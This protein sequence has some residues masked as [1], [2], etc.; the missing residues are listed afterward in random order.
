MLE[1]ITGRSRKR[2]YALASQFGITDIPQPAGG[3]KLTEPG[4]GKKLKML[5]E[6][7]TVFRQMTSNYYHPDAFSGRMTQLLLSLAIKKIAIR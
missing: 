4:Y 6:K 3:C 1:A 7:K 2:Q 5:L